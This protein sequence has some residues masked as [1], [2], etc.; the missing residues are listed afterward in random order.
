M[1][2]HY[3]ISISTSD[4]KLTAYL[5][6]NHPDDDVKVTADQLEDLLK[7]SRVIHGIDYDKLQQIANDPKAFC[8]MQVVVA[9]GD[10]PI[11]GQNG[12]IKHLYDLENDNRKPLELEDGKVDFKEVSTI[13]NVLKGQLIAQRIPATEGI[14]G[15]AVT[16]EV[17]FPK[18]GKE[19]RF[20]IGKNVVVDNEQ[21]NMYAAIDG[22][23]TKTERDKVNVFPIYEVNGDVDYAIGNIDF[24]GNVVIRGS[25]L[26][27]FKIKAGGDI[28]I[29][30][31]VEAAELEAGGSIEIS[32]GILGQNKGLIKAGKNVKSSFIQDATVEAGDEI[33][34]SQSIMHSH[35]RAGK[36][37]I[38][39]G[40]KGLIVGGVV[41]A[42][43]RVVSRTI[44]NSMSTATVIEV[45]VLPE[46]RNELQQLRLQLKALNENLE[47]TEKAL[48]LLDQLAAGGQL[49]PDKISMRIKLNHTKKQAFEE[50][51][52]ARERVLEIEKTLEDTELAKVEVSGMIYGGAKIVIGRY[53][54][55]VKDAAQRVVYK[56]VEGEI[57]TLPMG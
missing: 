31:G 48:S 54:K 51:T 27:G 10:P 6:F 38:C 43:E 57:A 2:L 18:A 8:F 56:L 44:G 4:D 12:Y 53:T 29:T 16:G 39:R 19:A 32:A 22:I 26:P 11:D 50:Q 40:T 45:G 30:G 35:I 13:N 25:V 5:T 37:V 47:K 14:Q 9:K 52:A 46:L 28:R 34:V 3:Y 24:V 23:V 33:V 1:P 41:Q 15:R 49:G 36:N 21:T 20:K 17:M 42:G 7:A 55:F